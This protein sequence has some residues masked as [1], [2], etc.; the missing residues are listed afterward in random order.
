MSDHGAYEFG[1][2]LGDGPLGAGDSA[3]GEPV[4]A[5]GAL[6]EPPFD[7]VDPC[8]MSAAERRLGELFL[9]LR[10]ELPVADAVLLVA[11]VV[12]L[13]AGTEV[14]FGLDGELNEAGAALSASIT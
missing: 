3:A 9:S 6:A 10:S 4:T 8:G 12:L 7:G 2:P 5:I 11:A 13:E 1:L 14:L